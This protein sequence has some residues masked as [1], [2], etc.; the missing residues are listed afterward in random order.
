LDSCL[1]RQYR[2]KTISG[3]HSINPCPLNPQ[4]VPARFTPEQE[5]KSPAIQPST[6][7]DMCLSRQYRP[8]TIS[9]S[10][11]INLCPLNPPKQSKPEPIT[12]FG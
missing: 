6:Q 4:N 1:S 10:H 9:G 2:P 3:S 5:A 7:L 8:K 11:S 12:F